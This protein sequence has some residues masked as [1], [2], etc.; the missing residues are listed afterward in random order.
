LTAVR[1]PAE[2]TLPA[3]AGTDLFTDPAGGAPVANAPRVLHRLPDGDF[4]LSAR[5]SVDFAQTYDAGVLLAWWDERHW[6]KLCFERSPQGR[7]MVVSVVNRDVSDDANGF[8]VDG[9]TLWLRISRLG[10]ALAF[11]AARDGRHWEFVRYFAVDPV[12]PAAELSVGFEA[13][14]P[15][16]AG[17]TARF[18]E[19]RYLPQ[20]LADLRDGS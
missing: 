8:G 15:L 9:D 7:P 6:A 16:G 14:S 5:V 1:L 19:I 11:H 18:T 2:M 4:Q 20:R 3:P 17:C 12:D 10:R 13:Q